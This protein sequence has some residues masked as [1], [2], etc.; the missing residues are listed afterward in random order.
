MRIRMEFFLEN[1]ICPSEYRRCLMSF[2]KMA[3]SNLKSGEKFTEYYHDTCQKDFTWC[4]ILPNP[5]FDKD[6]VMLSNNSFSVILSTDDRKQ[7]GFYMMMALINQK[8]RE[9]PL[10]KSNTMVLKNVRQL[11]QETILKDECK[12]FTMPGSPLVVRE[13]DRDGNSDRYYTIEDV[14]FVDALTEGIK[15]QL[16]IAGFDEQLIQDIYVENFIGRKVVVKHY[17]IF[18]DATVGE[19]LIKAP[20]IILQHIYQNGLASRRSAGYGMVD[21]RR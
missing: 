5:V 10:G 18:M 3:L 21:I 2:F 6:K 9:Y 17:G 11:R 8:G 4:T 15:Y 13:H 7:T 19:M 1:C 16:K 12:F 20:P 14:K